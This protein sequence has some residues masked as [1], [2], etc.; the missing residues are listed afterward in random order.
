MS[1]D[2]RI[3]IK[4]IC[5]YILSVCLSYVYYDIVEIDLHED[6]FSVL[7]AEIDDDYQSEKIEKWRSH[8]HMQIKK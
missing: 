1:I 5:F 6:D 3:S 8:Y 7:D 2:M 4:C